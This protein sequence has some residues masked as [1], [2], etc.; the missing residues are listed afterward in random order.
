MRHKEPAAGQIN[1]CYVNLENTV[2]VLSCLMLIGQIEALLAQTSSLLFPCHLPSWLIM[3]HFGALSLS[4][5]YVAELNSLL[6]LYQTPC[7]NVLGFYFL[8][9]LKDHLFVS[10]ARICFGETVRSLIAHM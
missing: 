10:S 5:L 3:V 8:L 6:S 4:S 1:V 2:F 7:F 9:V